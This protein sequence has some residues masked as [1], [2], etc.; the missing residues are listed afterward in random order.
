MNGSLGNF[1]GVNPNL[2]NEINLYMRK[3]SS[4]VSEEFFNNWNEHNFETM[5]EVVKISL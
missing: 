5:V 1:L 3:N 4:L 2:I